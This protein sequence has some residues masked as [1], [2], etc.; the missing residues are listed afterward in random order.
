MSFARAVHETEAKLGVEFSAVVVT[1]TVAM[2]GGSASN[3][4]VAFTGAAVASGS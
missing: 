4:E 1:L 2:N 3:V